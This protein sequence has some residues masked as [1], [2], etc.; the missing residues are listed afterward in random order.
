MNE[1]GRVTRLV[2]RLRLDTILE[3]VRGWL[4]N[5]S[6]E[7]EVESD[8]SVG[9]AGWVMSRVM[10]YTEPRWAGEAEAPERRG[11]LKP[12]GLLAGPISLSSSSQTHSATRPACARV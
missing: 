7:A 11:A 6:G 10:G 1:L 9:R 12:S 8:G 5:E 3:R 4:T 2:R